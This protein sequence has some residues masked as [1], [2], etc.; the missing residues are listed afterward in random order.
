MRLHA[1]CVPHANT[2]TPEP[3]G[4]IDGLIAAQDIT[5]ALELDSPAVA[6]LCTLEERAAVH[7]G[8][9]G[10]QEDDHGPSVAMLDPAAGVGVRLPSTCIRVPL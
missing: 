9:G 5:L 3:P 1:P 8:V 2:C 7:Y 10:S 4:V 6:A